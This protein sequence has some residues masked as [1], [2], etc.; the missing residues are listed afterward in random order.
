VRRLFFDVLLATVNGV[1]YTIGVAVIIYLFWPVF[2]ALRRLAN[3]QPIDAAELSALRARCLRMGDYAAWVSALEWTISGFVFPFWMHMQ[4]G[5]GLSFHHYIHFITSQVLCG[6]MSATLT[7]FF[8]TFIAVRIVYPWFVQ[9][10][11]TEADESQQLVALSRRIW[12]YF[13]LTGIVPF[14]ALPSIVMLAGR[15]ADEDTAGGGLGPLLGLGAVGLVAFVLALWF[16][17]A[18]RGDIAALAAAIDPAGV[19]L[20]TFGES[21]DS[22]RTGSR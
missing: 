6:L 12:L 9:P 3:R 21:S 18:I 11:T 4:T 10:A 5:S 2:R 19:S 22:F 20:A 17:R 15:W 7:F 8:I 16:D 13:L 14:L 1:A